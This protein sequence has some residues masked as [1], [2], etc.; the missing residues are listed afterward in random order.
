LITIQINGVEIVGRLN[1]PGPTIGA[2]GLRADAG[3]GPI[4]VAFD[5]FVIRPVQ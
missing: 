4:T 1:D 3:T 5:N 2:V